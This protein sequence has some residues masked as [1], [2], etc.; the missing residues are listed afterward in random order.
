V[1]LLPDGSVR[2]LIANA[3][4]HQNFLIGGA[5]PMIEI[6]PNRVEISNPGEPIV[7]V[8]RFIDGYQ[9]RNERLADFMRRMSICE[10]QDEHLR[11]EEQWD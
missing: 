8:E 9:S 6:Y 11:R 10:E 1:K 5:T 3:L 2:E 7:P 4:I